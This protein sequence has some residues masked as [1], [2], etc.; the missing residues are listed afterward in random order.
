M[1]PEAVQSQNP[2]RFK[3]KYET[4]LPALEE[5]SSLTDIVLEKP[6]E[7]RNGPRNSVTE[8]YFKIKK[9]SVEA[10]P[11]G[12]LPIDLVETA[13]RLSVALSSVK[14][15]VTE[16]HHGDRIAKAALESLKA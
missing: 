11:D 9:K 1:N 3:V 8:V 10:V 2:G 16:I 15:V 14:H 12:T 7:N 6:E 5:I 4:I 13:S